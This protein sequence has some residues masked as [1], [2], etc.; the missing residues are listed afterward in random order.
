MDVSDNVSLLV[1]SIDPFLVVDGGVTSK[2]SFWETPCLD[3]A[4]RLIT[5]KGLKEV[6]FYLSNRYLP[7]FH[8]GWEVSVGWF[9]QQQTPAIDI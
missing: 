8:M 9:W 1:V 2:A 6:P 3:G 7:I 4:L 5:S